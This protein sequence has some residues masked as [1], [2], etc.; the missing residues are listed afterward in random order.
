MGPDPKKVAQ[1]FQDPML[2][3]LKQKGVTRTMIVEDYLVR[4]ALLRKVLKGKKSIRKNLDL[5]IIKELRAEAEHICAVAGWK[6]PERHEI[7]NRMTVT[8]V[9][10]YPEGE[11][12]PE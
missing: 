11:E 9:D 6:A 10:K 7:D 3:I 8:V 12:A 2:R 1:L 5:G 4:S